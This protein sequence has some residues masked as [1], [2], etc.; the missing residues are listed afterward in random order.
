M[1]KPHSSVAISLQMKSA[2]ETT[3]FAGNL[4]LA[5]FV[6]PGNWCGYVLCG[7]IVYVC[8]ILV[9]QSLKQGNNDVIG[10][11]MPC[12]EGVV[13]AFRAMYNGIV[14]DAVG[15]DERYCTVCNGRS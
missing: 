13:G 15:G 8:K 12:V 10:R 4:I 2:T 5:I 3:C 11:D 7:G 9:V 6:E 14:D 1:K